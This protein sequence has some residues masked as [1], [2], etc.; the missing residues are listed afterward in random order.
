VTTA[1]KA[2]YTVLVQQWLTTNLF[3]NCPSKHLHCALQTLGNLVAA[4][5][6]FS[7]QISPFI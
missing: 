4:A 2:R 5:N 1:S 6:C 7:K 3:Q